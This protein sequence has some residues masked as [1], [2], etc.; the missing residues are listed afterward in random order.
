MTV[1]VDTVLP[2]NNVQDALIEDICLARVMAFR[3]T[4]LYKIKTGSPHVQNNIGIK[5][6]MRFMQD[7]K[8]KRCN[9]NHFVKDSIIELATGERGCEV[10][11]DRSRVTL[12]FS[13][14]ISLCLRGHLK[15]AVSGLHGS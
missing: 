12:A 10:R 9:A 7:E 11:N 4:T 6:R 8:Q 3:T 15:V 1:G 5:V 2:L 14:L 13:P